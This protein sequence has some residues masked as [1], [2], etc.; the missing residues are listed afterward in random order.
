MVL[1]GAAILIAQA[2]ASAAKAGGEYYANKKGEKAAKR[3]AKEKKR[4]TI[5]GL[6]NDAMQGSAE[7]AAHHLKEKGKL[8]KRKGKS[9]QDTAELV[10]GALNI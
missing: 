6:M 10:R 9:S 4:E 5:A 2:I 1:P 7:N 3:S 8:G